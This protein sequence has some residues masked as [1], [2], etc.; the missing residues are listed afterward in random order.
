MIIVVTSSN[1]NNDSI[2]NNNHISNNNISNIGNISN[3]NNNRERVI[4]TLIKKV[5]T[6]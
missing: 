2:S 3:S 5:D 6:N 1:S 4:I